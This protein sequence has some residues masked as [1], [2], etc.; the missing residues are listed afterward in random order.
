MKRGARLLLIVTLLA[1]VASAAF[2][3][4][5]WCRNLL[6]QSGPSVAVQRFAVPAGS[7][8]TAVIQRLG[9][10][11]LVSHPQIVATYLRWRRPGISIQAGEYD[12]NAG[13]SVN[14]ILEQLRSGRVVLE[15]ITLIEG[16][17]FDQ[18]RQAIARHP[19]LSQTLTGRSDSEVMTLLG[20]GEL[21]P[22]GQLYPDT[23]RF[24]AGSTDLALLRRAHERLQ[25]E[26]AT[27]WSVRANTE[28][29]ESPYQVLTLASL[30]EKETALPGERARIAGV[31][32][33]RLRRGM[34]LQSDPTVIYGMGARYDG[35]I[36]SR[37]LRADTPYNTYTRAGLPP[38]PIALVGKE[39]L[40]AVTQPEITGD[41]Y[42]VATGDGDGSHFFSSNYAA[43]ADAVR[44]YL[45]KLKLQGTR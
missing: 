23:Y 45:A 38:T 5:L 17:T 40:L 43:H 11:G 27:A 14:D 30:V 33:L 34:R 3:G 7:S 10:A 37:D 32:L 21:H 19:A 8:L 24:A 20:S 36:R 1:L 41:L 35:D 26:L 13:A 28:P 16:W 44:R 18:A 15:S 12:I 31:F 29:L 6:R 9:R 39:A 2:A 42:F 22:E 4:E 25:Q